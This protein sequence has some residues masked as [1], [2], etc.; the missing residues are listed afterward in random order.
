MIN[1]IAWKWEKFAT[2]IAN[3]ECAEYTKSLENEYKD[4]GNKTGNL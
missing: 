1:L 3:K 4:T 2:N